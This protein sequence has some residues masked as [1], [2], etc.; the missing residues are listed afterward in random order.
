MMNNPDKPDD[1][2]DN[3]TRTLADGPSATSDSSIQKSS[4]QKRVLSSKEKVEPQSQPPIPLRI[5]AAQS[6]RG[7]NAPPPGV[8][9]VST[10]GAQVERDVRLGE[11]QSSIDV[12][13]AKSFALVAKREGI[14]QNPDDLSAS[15]QDSKP[16]WWDDDSWTAY[17]RPGLL[18]DPKILK[19][20]DSD[21][22]SETIASLGAWRE[23]GTITLPTTLRTTHPWL[24]RKFEIAAEVAGISIATSND[25]I[26]IEAKPG[27]MSM[28][29]DTR[30]QALEG[31]KAKRDFETLRAVNLT[32]TLAEGLLKAPTEKFLETCD[33]NPGRK[34]LARLISIIYAEQA[35]NLR[36]GEQRALWKD[37]LSR[38]EIISEVAKVL[39]SQQAAVLYVGAVD[40]VMR[41]LVRRSLNP[42]CDDNKTP[43]LYWR[44]EEF[45]E[46]W[47]EDECLRAK[48]AAALA[49][50]LQKLCR[51][52]AASGATM[53]LRS[54]PTTTHKV[55]ENAT[56]PP[57]WKPS[58]KGDVYQ[59]V[60]K[61]TALVKPKL[62]SGPM[63]P[64][65]E[66]VTKRIN[67]VLS[68]IESDLGPQVGPEAG[69]RPED[70][71]SRCQRAADK[72]R[73]RVESLESEIRRRRNELRQTI[74][75]ERG[76]IVP[77]GKPQGTTQSLQEA[78]I[79]PTEWQRAAAKYLER[80][81]SRGSKLFLDGLSSLLQCD[82]SL[83]D[84][85]E[86]TD[87]DLKMAIIRSVLLVN[88]YHE[89][90]R[91]RDEV[92]CYL[93]TLKPA[94]RTDIP[95]DGERPVA[96]KKEITTTIPTSAQRQ[97]GGETLLA[98]MS[99]TLEAQPA[100]SIKETA[101]E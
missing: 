12:T 62:S 93:K 21:S 19:L 3:P 82:V 15:S 95:E 38:S 99:A 32:A 72:L 80:N 35:A 13:T 63:L 41:S 78:V 33:Q 73:N 8:I 71:L 97:E 53:I 69:G 34:Y 48:H 22:I 83:D 7:G 87:Y 30:K 23:Q 89:K 28:D 66:Q 96:P 37:T 52:Q 40:T 27:A 65:E 74:L 26:V 57:D 50:R 46:T 76:V 24:W 85:L 54:F 94:S 67:I 4:K 70:W 98:L 86:L 91:L 20:L 39:G 16:S 2:C 25:V 56:A 11:S 42:M 55:L 59:K 10:L 45:M 14:G 1:S 9:D 60:V 79:Q 84:V 29:M 6:W 64:G 5:G 61:K 49:K 75:V 58:K 51:N 77:K 101:S 47:T 81:S 92:D 90:V 100:V 36:L 43:L 17:A 31:Y 88:P 68:Q 44:A 18:T